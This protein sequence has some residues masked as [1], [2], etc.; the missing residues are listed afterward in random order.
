MPLNF[1]PMQAPIQLILVIRGVFNIAC[2][3]VGAQKSS[4]VTFLCSHLPGFWKN[5]FHF[6]YMFMCAHR[7]PWMLEKLGHY[8]TG[9]IGSCESLNLGV[10]SEHLSSY[11][12]SRCY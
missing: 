8:G 1:R 5:T 9:V 12:S 3:V 11:K 7:C 4:I 2:A 10:L 6:F